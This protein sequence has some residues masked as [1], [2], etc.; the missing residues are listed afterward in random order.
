MELKNIIVS[1]E[2]RPFMYINNTDIY[3]LDTFINGYLYGKSDNLSPME[4]EF[5]SSFHIWVQEYYDAPTSFPWCNTI[6][7]YENNHYKAFEKFFDLYKR[8][9]EC[10]EG[11]KNETNSI[12]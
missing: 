11:K 10:V 1:L 4:K 8:W 12:N 3:M 2:K 9:Y 6:Y 7:Y 5:R